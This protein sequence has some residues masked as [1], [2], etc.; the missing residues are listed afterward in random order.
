MSSSAGSAGA[1]P[2][3]ATIPVICGPTASG[4]SAV[5]MW[6]A[7]R[8]DIEV[9]SADSRQIYHGFDVGTAKPSR[10]DRT[11]VPHHGIDVAD[12]T[13]RYSAARWAEMAHEAI[14][15]AF[16][17][18]RVPIVVGGTGF[19]IAALFRPLWAQ[20]DMEP[21]SRETLQRALAPH[22]TDELRRWCRELDPDRAH[23]GRAQLLRAI[24][25][26]LLTGKRLSA[27]HL[28]RARRPLLKS[29]YLLVDPGPEL[30]GRIATRTAEMLEAG[31]PAEVRRL[32]DA[33]PSGAPAWKASG[34]DVV[35]RHV[36]GEIDR[37]ATLE[38]III[39]TRQYAKRQRTWFRNQLEA[40]RVRRLS[41]LDR[42]WEGEVDAW[43]EDV[44]KAMRPS[45]RDS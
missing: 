16:A 20:P 1:E 43:M 28:E 40:D 24:E 14:E 33:V 11:R 2:G 34:Y 17:R 22:T 3:L 37:S 45:E 18:S 36:S 8:H 10:E 21:A 42:G 31:W 27:M 32:M 5:A 39:E 4:K 15:G 9:V 30:H 38:Q 12:P 13:E 41:P 26:C 19:Y 7:S 23:L 25:V 6:L 35:R 44:E 29:S